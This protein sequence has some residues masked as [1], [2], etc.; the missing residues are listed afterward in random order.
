MS[1]PSS[2]RWLAAT[3]LTLAVLV[4]G[5]AAHAQ[6]T[7]TFNGFFNNENQ[8]VSFTVQRP[9]AIVGPVAAVP[10]PCTI[11][12]AEFNAET[13]SCASTSFSEN[14]FGTGLNLVDFGFS[15][16]FENGGGG[17]GSWYFFEPGIFAT[18]GVHNTVT[19]NDARL[20]VDNPLF[21]AEDAECEGL[22]VNDCEDIRRQYNYYGSAG[23][24][25]LTI[26]GPTGT[27]VPEPSSALL[28]GAGLAGLAGVARRRKPAQ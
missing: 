28:V 22:A 10:T 17:G 3:A 15:T 20:R 2:S 7:Y 23:V 11:T 8:T 24:A 1:I 13:Y 18:V 6:W 14:G 16:V 12:P 4:P 26:A 19:N 5:R 9:S 21:I 27:P 25:T